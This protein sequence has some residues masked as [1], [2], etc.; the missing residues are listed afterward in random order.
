MMLAR[1]LCLSGVDSVASDGA[2]AGVPQTAAVAVV[3]TSAA[4]VVV[5]A[6]A[7]ATTVEFVCFRLVAVV[8][9]FLVA[10]RHLNVCLHSLRL[11]FRGDMSRAVSVAA[12]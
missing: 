3:V 7:S 4:V 9:L 6:S 11:H 2:A 5:A 1:L 12:V 8:A 10:V